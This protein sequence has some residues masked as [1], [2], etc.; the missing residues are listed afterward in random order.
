M[1]VVEVAAG[2]AALTLDGWE[3]DRTDATGL[4]GR[5]AVARR[6]SRASLTADEVAHETGDHE[7]LLQLPMIFRRS[8][9]ERA[10]QN[11]DAK[12]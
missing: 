2:D 4:T 11:V 12:N 7:S 5:I 9:D 8:T 10:V 1:E 3:G 6:A